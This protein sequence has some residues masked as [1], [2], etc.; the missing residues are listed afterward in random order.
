MKKVSIGILNRNGIDRL[1]KTV[2]SVLNQDYEDLEVVFF[3]NGSTDQ[4]IDFLRKFEQIKIVQS[5]SNLGYGKGKNRLVESC[6]GEYIL[7]L[8]N[9]IEL[10]D[11]KTIS[12]LLRACEECGGECFISPL[13]LDDGSDTTTTGLFYSKV[14]K[15]QKLNKI[16]NFGL[17][18][19]GAYR[20]NTVFFKKDVFLRLGMYDEIYPFNIDDYDMSARASINGL[21]IFTYTDCVV[22]H[23]GIE[24][25]I[26]ASSLAWKYKYHFCGFCRMMV[27]NYALKNLLFWFPIVFVWITIKAIR[28]SFLSK[29]LKPFFS[30]LL[31]ISYFIR[32]IKSS[33]A[34]R[35]KIQSHRKNKLD[36]FLAIKP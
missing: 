16:E 33:L 15:P 27:K 11:A 19:I 35:K 1:K 6:S 23:H 13:V 32:D 22:I 17:I 25:R 9:D 24:S 8:D 10:R 30:H 14:S 29:S 21:K 3:D 4:S 12:K 26:N 18:E 34:E 2:N 36:S 28:N 7:L 5:D 20:G 31:S